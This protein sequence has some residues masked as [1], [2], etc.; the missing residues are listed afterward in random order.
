MIRVAPANRSGLLCLRLV[1][2]MLHI[3][4]AVRQVLIGVAAGCS[5]QEH[6]IQ[7]QVLE[8]AVSGSL[9]PS[10]ALHV[11]RNEWHIDMAV[12]AAS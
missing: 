5:G 2:V 8:T 10:G 9:W 3:M 11:V 6:N 1:N 12:L 7:L 4:V